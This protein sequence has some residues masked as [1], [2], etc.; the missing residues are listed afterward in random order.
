M[1]AA[2]LVAACAPAPPRPA[3]A[4]SAP[5]SDARLL[6]PLA[7]LIG[8]RSADLDATGLPRPGSL[9]LFR[10]FQVP[11]AVAARG[12][13]VYVVDSGRREILRY[14]RFQNSVTLPVASL[15]PTPDT[16]IRAGTDGSLYVL[17]TVAR[18]VQRFSRSGQRLQVYG[19]SLNLPRPIDFV[20][21]EARGR[22][23]VADATYQQLVEFH[24]AGRVAY[25]T[26]GGGGER[27][28]LGGIVG[29]SLVP[30]GI[31]VA[32][33]ACGCLVDYSP[34][35]GRTTRYGR[36]L[37]GRPGALAADR[38]G[39]LFVLDNQDRSIRVFRG[40]TAIAR[41]GYP[42]LGLTAPAGVAVDDDTLYVADSAAARVAV[43]HIAPPAKVSRP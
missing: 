32:D 14:D 25:P 10:N 20:V 33:A 19:D 42:S 34:D 21:D 17:D 3:G 36:E 5:R 38:H 13:D 24:P 29:L 43:F 18:N 37:G 39:R 4:D 7:P 22:V 6:T 9:G 31:A 30:G 41:L 8:G 26:L 28:P 27:G 2:A 15:R 12:P 11:T 35:S 16:R 1:V 23:V 40:Q